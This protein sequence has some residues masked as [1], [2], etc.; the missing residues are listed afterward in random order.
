MPS[1]SRRCPCC[2]LPARDFGKIASVSADDGQTHGLVGICQRCTTA[3]TR[4]PKS[5]RWKR[6]N[7]ALDRALAEPEKYLVKIYPDIGAAQVALALL[8]HPEHGARDILDSLGW[9]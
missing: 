8:Q 1:P 7:R 3:E 4:L 9:W 2:G 6:M 5:I